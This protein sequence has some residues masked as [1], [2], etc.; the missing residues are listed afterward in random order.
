MLVVLLCV[1]CCVVL[2]CMLCCVVVCVVLCC[3]VTTVTLRMQRSVS[4]N[5]FPVHEF[6]F[7]PVLKN[8]GVV[9]C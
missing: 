2:L 5:A 3:A 4:C 8:M 7:S 1:L 6:Y 9:E